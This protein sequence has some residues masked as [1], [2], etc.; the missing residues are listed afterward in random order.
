MPHPLKVLE[1][2]VALTFGRLLIG[3]VSGETIGSTFVPL[4]DWRWLLAVPAA[5]LLACIVEIV[6]NPD[7]FE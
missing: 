6:V 7:A 5:L 3:R 2:V 1:V 4:L